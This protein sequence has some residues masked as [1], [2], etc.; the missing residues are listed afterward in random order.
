MTRQLRIVTEAA[1]AEPVTMGEAIMEVSREAAASNPV[2]ALIIW[3][4]GNSLFAKA[5]PNSSVL[6]RGIIDMLFEQLHPETM[7]E[8]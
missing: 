3:E 1:S 7:S 5:V 6:K 2:S 8:S 4:V